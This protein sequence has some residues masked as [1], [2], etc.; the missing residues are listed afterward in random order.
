V[1]Y[2][3]ILQ[4]RTFASNISSSSTAVRP[5]HQWQNDRPWSARLAFCLWKNEVTRRDRQGRDTGKEKGA[6]KSPIPLVNV[7]HVWDQNTE[8]DAEYD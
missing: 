8:N 6:S 5:D 2:D 3:A 7:D 4:A 1:T